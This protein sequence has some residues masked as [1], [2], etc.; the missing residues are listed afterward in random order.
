MKC[1]KD[2]LDCFHE[3][4]TRASMRKATKQFNHSSLKP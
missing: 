4:E 1:F 2:E 3:L